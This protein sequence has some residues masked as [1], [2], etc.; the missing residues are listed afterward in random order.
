M[1]I[2]FT[3]FIIFIII[4]GLCMSGLLF[5]IISLLFEAVLACLEWFFSGCFNFILII[6][7][8]IG[9]LSIL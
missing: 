1:E 4:I 3:L 2:L 7:I 8:I 9:I 6:I 5:K